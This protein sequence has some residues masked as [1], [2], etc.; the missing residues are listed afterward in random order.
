LIEVHREVGVVLKRNL[1][2]H[3]ERKLNEIKKIFVEPRKSKIRIKKHSYAEI[4]QDQTVPKNDEY[5]NRGLALILKLYRKCF[6]RLKSWHET[7]S[8]NEKESEKLQSQLLI[9]LDK[10]E[11]ANEELRTQSESGSLSSMIENNYLRGFLMLQNAEAV[12]DAVIAGA[13]TDA[14]ACQMIRKALSC[15]SLISASDQRG[16]S[17]ATDIDEVY[18]RVLGNGQK[19][20]KAAGDNN[21]LFHTLGQLLRD[22]EEPF[23]EDH[24]QLREFLV[25]SALRRHTPP[26]MAR[27][28]Q[29]NS[30][31]KESIQDWAL[32]MEKPGVWGDEDVIDQFA[33]TYNIRVRLYCQLN[34]VEPPEMGYKM[35]PISGSP[36]TMKTVSLAH[37]PTLLTKK[38][39]HFVPVWPVHQALHENDRISGVC[40]DIQVPQAVDDSAADPAVR[41]L[42]S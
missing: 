8:K 40:Q 31:T 3:L 20:G 19:L 27:K 34:D 13:V 14:Q 41:S 28:F 30:V 16:S 1:E 25:R 24:L 38:G 18:R 5:R 12:D 21:C 39:D 6:G 32:R 33:V 36:S 15:Q 9:F 26:D 17:E 29:T 2:A 23:Q 35:F 42:I 11:S 4:V 7:E 37:L 22:I 10:L